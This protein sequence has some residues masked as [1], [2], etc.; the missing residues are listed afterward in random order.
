MERDTMENV[1][2]ALLQDIE[3]TG[4]TDYDDLPEDIRKRIEQCVVVE[5]IVVGL[6]A[7]KTELRES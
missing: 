6:E 1:R 5:A 2:L 4:V 7:I 3:R